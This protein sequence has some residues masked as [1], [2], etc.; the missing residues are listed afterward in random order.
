MTS[1]DSDGKISYLGIPMGAKFRFLPPTELV[2]SLHKVA[3]SGLFP[4]QKLEVYRN[5]LLPAL[6][7]HLG[8][9]R[10]LKKDLHG[11]DV[12]C[13]VFLAKVTTVG[14]TSTTPFYYADR[15]SGAPGR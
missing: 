2:Q 4:W 6:A 9:A 14:K 12:D 5:H 3:D 8:S 1:L 10:A 7:H 15:Q 11:L 13:R